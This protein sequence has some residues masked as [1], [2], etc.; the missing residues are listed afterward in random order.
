[1]NFAILRVA[2]L[3]NIGAIA[4]SAKHNFRE[5]VTENADEAYTPWN[6]H[7]GAK[8]AD[9]LV[10]GVSDLLPAKR[11]KD[12]VA[13]LEYLITASP[14]AFGDWR[15]TGDV[16]SDYFN[17]SLAWL[18][19]RHG[20]ENVVSVSIHLDESTPH[21]VA[22][23]VPK[24]ADGRLAAKDFV[25]GKAKLTAMQT[26]FAEQV[27]KKHGLERGVER[28]Q[29][30][31]MPSGDRRGVAVMAAEIK[32]LEAEI[33][34]LTKTV[35]AGGDAQKNLEKELARQRKLSLKFSDQLTVKESEVKELKIEAI[36]REQHYKE[37]A[38]KYQQFLADGGKGE[39]FD[40]GEKPEFVED[41]P[42]VEDTG[43]AD[44]SAGLKEAAPSIVKHAVLVEV[45]PDGKRAIYDVGRGVLVVGDM[46]KEENHRGGRGGRV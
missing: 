8:S 45:S 10:K 13:V 23:V 35:D 26:Q 42:E 18:H 37:L 43:F 36:T 33:E 15:K 7:S 11:R 31:H 3:K 1:M 25:G 27:G 4:A 9:E 20:A 5:R 6:Q 22:Y 17:D 14:E 40:P 32:R 46:R 39:E 24:T 34:R 41:E 2:K 28:S 21:L 19:K 38:E 16:K 44:R 29:A 12:A 30:R